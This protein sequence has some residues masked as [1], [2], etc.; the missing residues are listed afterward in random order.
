M[1]FVQLC[2]WPLLCHFERREKSVPDLGKRLLSRTVVGIEVT[3]ICFL[4]LF[5]QVFG[6]IVSMAFPCHFG[7]DGYRERNLD[8]WLPDARDRHWFLFPISRLSLLASNILCLIRH[9][10]QA[11]Q[12]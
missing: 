1:I 3:R 5:H 12:F 11:S 10:G 4:L 7:P 9:G 8:S 6:S 2:Q